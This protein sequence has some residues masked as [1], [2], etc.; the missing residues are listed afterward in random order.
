MRKRMLLAGL[1]AAAFLLY[2]AFIIP[3]LS[4]GYSITFSAL[5]AAILSLFFVLGTVAFWLLY[6]KHV[7]NAQ[8][9]LPE[10]LLYVLGTILYLGNVGL[11]LWVGVI[12]QHIW[13]VLPL[14]IPA[15]PAIY[16]IAS[17]ILPR[18]LRYVS[19]GVIAL[20]CGLITLSMLIVIFF[21][22]FPFGSSTILRTLDSPDG[23][24]CAFLLSHD[25]GATGG[26][27]EVGIRE[28]GK[29]VRLGLC[30]YK[31]KAAYVY[32]GGWGMQ[33]SVTMEWVDDETILINDESY[34]AR[35]VLHP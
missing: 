2:P 34:S 20:P 11:L 28:K 4:R 5:Q 16:L 9:T 15:C 6:R 26:S 29:D 32:V 21:T 7:A 25:A 14:L 1:F 24:Y 22:L 23:T 27:T 3:G 13:A 19:L 31:V 12:E 33:D 18:W 10:S 35:Q 8:A 17:Y 30:D